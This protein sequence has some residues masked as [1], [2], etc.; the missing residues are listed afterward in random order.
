MWFGAFAV[1]R[2][3]TPSVAQHWKHPYRFRLSLID[4]LCTTRV[5]ERIYC[6]FLA[7]SSDGGRV[8]TVKTLATHG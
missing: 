4:I 5:G 1:S 6:A 2:V 8:E 3:P 7:R